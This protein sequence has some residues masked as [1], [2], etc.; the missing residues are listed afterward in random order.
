MAENPDGPA[1]S[2]R[3]TS[4][5]TWAMLA[6]SVLT[7]VII[8]TD[9]VLD[10]QEG[11]DLRD[12]ILEAVAMVAAF[13]NSLALSIMLARDA[14]RAQSALKE[15][16][17]EVDLAKARIASLAEE[18]ARWKED[19]QDALREFGGAI[20]KQFARWSLT[21]A[22]CEVALL[23][24][25]GLPTKDI[26]ELRS[27]SDQTVRQQARAIYK[28]AGLRNRAELAAWFLEDLMLP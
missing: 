28:K 23:L 7:A 27:T 4:R 19:A 15:A 20:D 26:A 10:F 21:P 25:K 22:E 14:R 8:G 3:G 1:Q 12:V 24:L 17:D 2:A 16:L 13:V 5:T 11:T 6:L 18:A 9:L